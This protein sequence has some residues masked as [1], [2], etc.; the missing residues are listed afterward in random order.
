[1]TEPCYN[2]ATYKTVGIQT[3][4]LYLDVAGP[5]WAPAE[6]R[7][8]DDVAAGREGRIRRNRVPDFR[9]IPL[10]GYTRGV[11]ATVDERQQ[12]W[13]E[14]EAIIGGLLDPDVSGDL[15][16]LAPYLGLAS[17]TATIDAYPL[18]WIPGRPEGTMTYRRWTIDLECVDNPPDWQFDESP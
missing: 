3:P 18:N 1:M 15:V 9:T 14:A 13:A 5:L 7:G 12:S 16:L 2:L 10:V 6:H 17:G 11:G 8:E 4:T